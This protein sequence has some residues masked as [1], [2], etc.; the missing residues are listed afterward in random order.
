MHKINEWGNKYSEF[1]YTIYGIGIGSIFESVIL[2]LPVLRL[3]DLRFVL[4]LIYA[5]LSLSLVFTTIF[6]SLGMKSKHPLRLAMA[7]GVPAGV[8]LT[9]FVFAIFDIRFLPILLNS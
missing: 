6:T 8:F 9:L 7:N 2:L 4:L 3:Y 5:M 1:L